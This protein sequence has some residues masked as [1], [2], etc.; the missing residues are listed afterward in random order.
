MF[1]AH[2]HHHHHHHHLLIA[3]AALKIFLQSGVDVVVLEVGVGGRLDATNV[4]PAPVVCG[5]TSLGYDHM[6]MLGD[7]LPVSESMDGWMD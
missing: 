7:T 4:I 6:D 2:Y 1:D 5:I 3:A